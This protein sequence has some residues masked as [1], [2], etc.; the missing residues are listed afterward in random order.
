MFWVDQLVS[1]IIQSGKHLPYH[2]DDM[3]TPSGRVHVGA[4]RG[5]I[6]HDLIQKILLQQGK[7]SVYTYVFNDM[8]PMDGFPHYLP[9]SFRE[10]MGK[11]LFLIPS[12][13]VG[14][15]SLARCYGEEFIRTFNR[16]GVKPEIIWSS[17]WYRQG[18]F[19]AVIKESL[20]KVKIIRRLYQDISHYDKPGDW[21]PFQVICEK[22]GKVGTTIVTA[23]DGERVTYHCQ[24]DLVKWT[25]GCGYEGHISP[26]NG[27]GKLMWKVDWAAHWKVIGITIEGA[28]KDHMTE[29]GSHD[30][31]GAIC[32]QAFDYPTPFGFLY[33]W[34]L[35]RGGAKMSSSKGIGNSAREFSESLPPE[36][37]RFLL[38]RTNY[39]KA[40]IIDPNNNASLLDLYDE[41]D[42][43]ADSYF[44]S[45]KDQDIAKAW[46]MS[47]IGL[48]PKTKPFYPRFR[49]VVNYVQNPAVDIHEQFTKLKGKSLTVA[50]KA[51]LDERIKYAQVWIKN[52]APKE[53][54]FQ[55]SANIPVE[56][57]TLTKEQKTYLK[58][59]AE[60]LNSR[61]WEP[62]KLQQALYE[63]SKKQ[64]LPAKAAFQAIYLALIGKTHGPKAGW[65]LAHQQKGF[66]VKRFTEIQ[67]S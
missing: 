20:D 61:K 42:R 44:S 60:L 67:L 46:E 56:A 17:E 50:D 52:Y 54:V 25:Q 1:Q 22:C 34:F 41:Y 35:A 63:L 55:V 47:Q 4:L 53:A 11:P 45:R 36:L 24:P 9:E 5:V 62:E 10:H 14:Y 51:I 65:L 6:I 7:K 28:G 39:Q 13:E 26:Y 66:V 58:E 21:Y 30:L 18:K 12:P 23:W 59:A 37:L 49:D 43:F 27:T 57:A 38:V 33:E 2:V 48:I 40:I 3:K 64:G 31:S 32:E 8:D 16:L 15:P 29:G 19:N